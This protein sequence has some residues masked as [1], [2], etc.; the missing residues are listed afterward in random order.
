ML[1]FCRHH[2]MIYLN[3]SLCICQSFNE[4]IDPLSYCQTLHRNVNDIRTVLHFHFYTQS[5]GTT[6]MSF[7]QKLTVGLPTGSNRWG[8]GWVCDSPPDLNLFSTTSFY[9][10]QGCG[11]PCLSPKSSNSNLK[12]MLPWINFQFLRGSIILWLQ[13]ALE[14]ASSLRLQI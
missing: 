4:H 2:P 6:W 10:G 12:S 9:W 7:S 13:I 14:S 8:W 11:L 3:Q 5:K 1:N